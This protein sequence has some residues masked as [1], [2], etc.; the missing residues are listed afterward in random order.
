MNIDWGIVLNIIVLVVVISNFI[1][2]R[3]RRQDEEN[4][5]DHDDEEIYEDKEG[6][7]LTLDQTV[8]VVADADFSDLTNEF[9]RRGWSDERLS[10][11]TF[12]L[13][14]FLVLLGLFP[15]TSGQ[16]RIVPLDDDS[17]EMFVVYLEKFSDQATELF[18]DLTP[19]SLPDINDNELNDKTLRHFSQKLADQI[20]CDWT[21]D[22]AIEEYFAGMIKLRF[23]TPSNDDQPS[24]INSLTPVEVLLEILRRPI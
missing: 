2:S 11:A 9:R 16:Y 1:L 12:S 21:I 3:P 24:Q 20:F 5:V 6:G 23:G 7:P 19:S 15:E 13:R 8:D 18:V 4:E 14:K 10:Q 17:L 22:Y